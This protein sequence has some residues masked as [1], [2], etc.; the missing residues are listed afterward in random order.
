MSI[1]R[2]FDVSDYNEAVK[3]NMMTLVVVM[4]NMVVT[5]NLIGS[6]KLV[7]LFLHRL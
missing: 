3:V 1:K 4:V 6:L 7:P 2:E 5:M